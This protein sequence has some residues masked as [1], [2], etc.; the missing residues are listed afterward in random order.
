MRREVLGDA[1][2][3]AVAV[4]GVVAAAQVWAV[5]QR[6]GTEVVVNCLVIFLPSLLGLIAWIRRGRSVR[7]SLSW[8]VPLVIWMSAMVLIPAVPSLIASIGAAVGIVFAG[9][10][11]A[12][13]DA[14]A[15]W[16]RVVLREPLPRA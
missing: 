2:L 3:V 16:Y 14:A 9:L 6:T 8:T 1:A 11:V 15:G 12:T 13:D 4:L 10:M 7:A 5:A